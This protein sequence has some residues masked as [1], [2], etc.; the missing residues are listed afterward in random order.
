MFEKMELDETLEEYNKRIKKQ[1]E[2]HKH[3]FLSRFLETAE[4]TIK[5]KE[6]DNAIFKKP[7]FLRTKD[8]KNSPVKSPQKPKSILKSAKSIAEPKQ[9]LIKLEETKIKPEEI[10]P[11]AFTS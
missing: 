7:A 8:D 11:A 10:Q 5:K 9:E 4:N 3:N 2:A 1:Q 6:I